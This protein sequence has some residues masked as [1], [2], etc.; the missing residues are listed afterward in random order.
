MLRPTVSI[1]CV[2]VRVQPKG[3]QQQQQQQRERERE[4]EADEPSA[5]RAFSLSPY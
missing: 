2:V 1:I 3:G 5:E 4:R